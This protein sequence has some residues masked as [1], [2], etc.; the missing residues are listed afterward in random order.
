MV[1]RPSQPISCAPGRMH[2]LPPPLPSLHSFVQQ[3]L[4]EQALG[5]GCK[6]AGPHP[7]SPERG[8]KCYYRRGVQGTGGLQTLE[9]HMG[10]AKAS[11]GGDI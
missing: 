6:S 8:L 7:L 5:S 9:V 11:G 3:P 2:S 1:G 10:S 4:A